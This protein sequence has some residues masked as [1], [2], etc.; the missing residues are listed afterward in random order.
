MSSLGNRS[1]HG[2]DPSC[3]TCSSLSQALGLLPLADRIATESPQ[4]QEH[5]RDDTQGTDTGELRS[6][7]PADRPT[8][9][10]RKLSNREFLQELLDAMILREFNDYRGGLIASLISSGVSPEEIESIAHPDPTIHPTM[11]AMW[12]SRYLELKYPPFKSKLWDN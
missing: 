10:R 11:T 6:T 9:N 8:D 1:K 4:R 3:T 7:R 12:V 2:R 5:S